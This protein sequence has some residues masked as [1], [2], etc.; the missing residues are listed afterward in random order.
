MP[1]R[2]QTQWN[3]FD[4]AHRA[5]YNRGPMSPNRR[6]ITKCGESDMMHQVKLM[7]LIQ[8]LHDVVGRL[9]PKQIVNF[10][11][12]EPSFQ[13]EHK[14]IAVVINKS[15]NRPSCWQRGQSRFNDW[16]VVCPGNNGYVMKSCHLHGPLPSDL[17][18]RTLARLTGVSRDQHF[19]TLR[20]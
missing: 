4:P 10:N 6:R 15:R 2:E 8:A 19:Q 16:P 7:N 14:G 13:G 9:L 1:P 5:P 12:L 11:Y 17:R 20:H 18:L 3:R